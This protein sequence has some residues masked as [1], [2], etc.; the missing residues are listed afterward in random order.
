MMINELKS[1]CCFDFDKIENNTKKTIEFKINDNLNNCRTTL[2]RYY[3]FSKEILQSIINTPPW[4][5]KLF[6]YAV[7]IVKSADTHGIIQRVIVDGEWQIEGFKIAAGEWRR[8]QYFNT[9]AFWGQWIDIEK[10]ISRILKDEYIKKYFTENWNKYMIIDEYMSLA[11]GYG[12]HI[13]TADEI[14]EQI[15]TGSAQIYKNK[16]IK[17]H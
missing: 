12:N 11:K 13:I 5:T 2:S 8:R 10:T 6:R 9:V 3:T 4:G 7:E 15:R 14:I 1:V 16:L 17:N